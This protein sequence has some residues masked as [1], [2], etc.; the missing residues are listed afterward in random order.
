MRASVMSAVAVLVGT[1]AAAAASPLALPNNP[2]AIWTSRPAAMSTHPGWLR[3]PGPTFMGGAPREWTTADFTA[4]TTEPSAEAPAVLAP[5]G[6]AP[7]ELFHRRQVEVQVMTGTAFFPIGLGKSGRAMTFLPQLVRVGYVLNSA[8]PQRRRFRGAFEPMLEV[9]TF[10]IVNGPGSILVG[11][12][13]F[14]RYNFACLHRR[15]VTYYQL[16][17]GGS[18]T[19]AYRFPPTNLS[20]G[21]EFIIH[22]GYGVRY[23]LNDRWALCGEFDYHHF[24]NAGINRRNFGVN[25]LGGTF[26]ITRFLR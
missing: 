23:L 7:W 17:G 15:I 10:P 22:A 16:G 26:G 13:V 19:D 9:T 2:E 8:D 11:A 24:S 6:M 1:V 12:S 25:T 4:A 14:L 21:F 20:T 3:D 5:A 18:W